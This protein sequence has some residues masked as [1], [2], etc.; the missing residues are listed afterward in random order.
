MNK[1]MDQMMIE[2]ENTHIA[3][4]ML[5]IYQEFKENDPKLASDALK[6]HDDY[7]ARAKGK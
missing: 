7:S 5:D 4:S 2:M 1:K 6:L 3:A